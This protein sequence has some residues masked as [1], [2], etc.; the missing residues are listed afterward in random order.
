MTS[1]V[2]QL[3]LLGDDQAAH[4]RYG[5][6]PVPVTPIV[7]S[8]R[9]EYTATCP[10]CSAVHRHTRPGIRRGPCGATYTVPEATDDLPPP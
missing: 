8:G 1:P 3:S 2:R 5:P 4:E 7:T 10:R 6:A 9:T